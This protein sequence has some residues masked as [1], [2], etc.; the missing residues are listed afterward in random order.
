M[1]YFAKILRKI[2]LKLPLAI[3]FLL[4]VLLGLFLYG[5]NKKRRIAFRN[6]KLAFPVLQVSFL[7]SIHRAVDLKLGYIF[8][9]NP[10]FSRV[11]G[12][13]IFEIS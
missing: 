7:A 1:Y 10:F 2:L 5:N 6:I 4:G 8:I 3:I 9:S 12:L 11:F 13:Y